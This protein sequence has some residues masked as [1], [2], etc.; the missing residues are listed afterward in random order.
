M[1]TYISSNWTQNPILKHQFYSVS[2]LNDSSFYYLPV[3]VAYNHIQ[4]TTTLPP[5][6]ILIPVHPLTYPHIF[7]FSPFLLSQTSNLLLP[8]FPI[9]STLA[10]IHSMPYISIMAILFTVTYYFGSSL[11]GAMLHC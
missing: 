10:S 9:R 7:N 4:H 8:S 2:V 6:H 11:L 3:I 1:Y 5:L